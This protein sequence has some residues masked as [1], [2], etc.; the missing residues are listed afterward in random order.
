MHLLTQNN[1]ISSRT[2]E[3]FEVRFH[4]TDYARFEP[5]SVMTRLLNTVFREWNFDLTVLSTGLFDFG[6]SRREFKKMAKE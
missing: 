5:V 1:R 6:M 4:R 3:F 2:P